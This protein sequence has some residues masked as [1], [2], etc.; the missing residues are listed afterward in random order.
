MDARNRCAKKKKRNIYAKNFKKQLIGCM[1]LM[2]QTY[3]A[4]PGWTLIARAMK[5][6]KRKLE[7]NEREH[8]AHT[9][10]NNLNPFCPTRKT[11]RAY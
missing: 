2:T 8:E 9:L 3:G 10:I 11:Q 5:S 6:Y 4:F 7:K 1:V